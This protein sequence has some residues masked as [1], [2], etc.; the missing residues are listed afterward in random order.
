MQAKYIPF[1]LSALLT[2]SC[3]NSRAKSPDPAATPAQDVAASEIVPGDAV[4]EGTESPQNAGE[5]A[6]APAG[7]VESPSSDGEGD[8]VFGG[9]RF[10]KLVHYFGDIL[11]SDGP[12]TC[13]FSFTNVGEVP[14][15]V[16]EVVSS[17]GCTD[18]S[19]T[20]EPLRPGEKGKITATYDNEGGAIPFDKVL[21]VYV[22]NLKRPVILHLRGVVHEKKL[23]LG[24]LYPVHGGPLGIKETELKAGNLQ[25]GESVANESTVA[26][27]SSS[28]VSVSF[29]N[30]S[31]GLSLSV[32]PNPVPAGGTASLRVKVSASEGVWGKNYYYADV[33][34]GGK[35]TGL[36]LKVFAYTKANFDDMTEEE[37]AVAALPV[38]ETS[39]V[40]FGRVAR[41]TVV[42]GTFKFTNNGK[43]PFKALKI[44]SDTPGTEIDDLPDVPAGGKGT[45]R[46]RFD[47]SSVPEGEVLVIISLTT[48]SP[49]RP[50][51]NLFLSG[52]TF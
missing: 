23:P 47:T 33:L 11:V 28:P 34:A 6:P 40:N 30:V 50:I 20:R 21:T 25:Q 26:N 18:V 16:Y 49:L 48:N 7:V 10:D 27:L 38:F 46:V 8:F 5:A 22:S 9:L 14:A 41:G 15:A 36:K 43:S 45:V 29:S 35:F 31:E 3:V 1:I 2:L 4:P 13:T 32:S 37:K 44:D 24:E 12:Q 17:C 19:W 39:N 42:E 51:V 52:D